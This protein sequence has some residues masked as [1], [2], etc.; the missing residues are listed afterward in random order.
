MHSGCGLKNRLN[1]EE[2]VIFAQKSIFYL[3]EASWFKNTSAMYLRPIKI[4]NFQPDPAV[5][6]IICI[7]DCGS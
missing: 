1:Y 7:L 5:S 2:G 6:G 3:V 4:C